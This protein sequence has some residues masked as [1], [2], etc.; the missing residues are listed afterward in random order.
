[1][2]VMLFVAIPSK[3]VLERDGCCGESVVMIM[4]SRFARFWGGEDVIVVASVVVS[5]EEC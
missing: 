5:F 4:L 1:M 3:F 2:G